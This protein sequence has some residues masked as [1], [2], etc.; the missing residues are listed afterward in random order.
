MGGKNEPETALGLIAS[1]FQR[2]ERHHGFGAFRACKQ[3][4]FVDFEVVSR[5]FGR[6]ETFIG[7]FEGVSKTMESCILQ[8]LVDRWHRREEITAFVH[9][10]DATAS[11]ILVEK[12]W[13]LNEYFDKNHVVK[14]WERM[15]QQNQRVS[16]SMDKGTRF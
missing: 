11:A 4:M 5:S 13:K 10:Q 14:S 8:Q 2:L 12:G 15:Y 9:D 16:M 3:Q 1:C 6:Q 7:N